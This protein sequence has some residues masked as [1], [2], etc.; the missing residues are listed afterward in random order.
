MLCDLI[1]FFYF[2]RHLKH[3]LVTVK[4]DIENSKTSI[5][6]TVESRSTMIV[7][8]LYIANF[9]CTKYFLIIYLI[10]SGTVAAFSVTT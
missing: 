5:L 4:I 6:V 8:F 3:L 10:L 2:T 7:F 1:H 9:M